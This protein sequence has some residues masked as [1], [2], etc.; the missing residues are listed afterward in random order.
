MS[1]HTPLSPEQGQWNEAGFFALGQTTNRLLELS[2]GYLDVLTLPTKSHQQIV[3]FIC[4]L[5]VAFLK[6]GN[7]GKALVAPYPVRLWEGKIREPDVIVALT[8]NVARMGE[9]VSDGADIAVEVV[10]EDRD[11][12]LVQKRAEYAKAGIPEYWIVD[13]AEELITVLVLSDQD[14]VVHGVHAAGDTAKSAIL[15][16]FMADVRAVFDAGKE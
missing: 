1:L 9:Q 10:S 7:R 2:N 6:I 14:Y 15:N 13:P 11:R 3:F 5:F 16:G 12:D 8:P 4:T